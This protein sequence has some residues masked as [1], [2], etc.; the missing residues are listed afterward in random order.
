MV[1][2]DG[3]QVRDFNYVEDVVDALVMAA[4]SEEANGRIFNLGADDPI[5]LKDTAALMVRLFG[6][7][8]YEIVPFP[9]DRK[10]IDIGDYYGDYRQIRSRL[11]WRPATDLE[12][13]LAETLA[14]YQEHHEHYW[15][16]D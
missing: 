3:R 14:F 13:G 9:E 15:N 4:S 6:G 11:G 1:F 10:V 2:G 12:A 7:G 5:T 16:G 8:S